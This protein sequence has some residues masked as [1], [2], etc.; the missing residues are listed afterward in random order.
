M[1][2]QFYPMNELASEGGGAKQ[3]NDARSDGVCKILGLVLSFLHLFYDVIKA[4]Q[5]LGFFFTKI[6]RVFFHFVLI[7]TTNAWLQIA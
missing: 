3:M 1:F 6:L 5:S 4:K 7:T 2:V